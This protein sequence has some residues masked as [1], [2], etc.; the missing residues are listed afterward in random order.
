MPML[1]ISGEKNPLYLFQQSSNLFFTSLLF[2]HKICFKF[3]NA[4]CTLIP[5]R[6]L[7]M[8]L[9]KS[10]FVYIV[11][12]VFSDLHSLVWWCLNG[13]DFSSDLLILDHL[14]K[15]VSIIFCCCFGIKMATDG[16]R[17]A[18]RWDYHEGH[19]YSFWGF[20]SPTLPYFSVPSVH[21][22]CLFLGREASTWKEVY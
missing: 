22:D 4:V 5:L 2:P 11:T 9:I 10:P 7:I 21:I 1:V 18:F 19:L 12:S 20:Q 8:L 15:F 16:G 13:V 3:S 17:R 14:L 6:I